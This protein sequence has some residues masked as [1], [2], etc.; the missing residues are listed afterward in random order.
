MMKLLLPLS[1]LAAYATEPIEAGVASR[2]AAQSTYAQWSHGPSSDP[3]YFPIAVWLQDPRNA[4]AYKRAGIN[5]YVGLW[6]GPTESQLATTPRC[7]RP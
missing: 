3:T 1:L 7:S 6:Q 5:L 2:L 4:L